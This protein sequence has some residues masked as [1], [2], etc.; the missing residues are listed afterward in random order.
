MGRNNRP[1]VSEGTRLGNTCLW[2]ISHQVLEV[3]WLGN[4][5]RTF[6]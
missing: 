1:D 2:K 6:W 4:I 3:G 5:A